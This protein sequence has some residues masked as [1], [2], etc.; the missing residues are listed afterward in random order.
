MRGATVDAAMKV[1]PVPAHLLT[2]AEA[3]SAGAPVFVAENS[4]PERVQVRD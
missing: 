3:Q 4:T 1:S 2:G